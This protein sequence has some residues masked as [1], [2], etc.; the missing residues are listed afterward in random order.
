M[1]IPLD[2]QNKNF[3]GFKAIGEVDADDF[4]KIVIPQAEAFVAKT[5]KLNYLLKIETDLNNF[6]AGAWLQDAI[7][8]IKVFTKWNRAAIVTD[9]EGIK[10]FTE[11]FSKLMI[12]EFKCFTHDELDVAISWVSEE[13]TID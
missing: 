7:L 6:S 1:I 2:T 13:K 10:S 4:K 9:S 3:V 12:G 11:F 5:G 8:G